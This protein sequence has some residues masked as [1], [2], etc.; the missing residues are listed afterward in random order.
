M[1][2]IG[3]DLPAFLSRITNMLSMLGY[4]SSQL[5]RMAG[6]LGDLIMGFGHRL[7]L[8]SE[9]HDAIRDRRKGLWEISEIVRRN[10]ERTQEFD[11]TKTPLAGLPLHVSLEEGRHDVSHLLLKKY[12]EA[13]EVACQGGR[14]PLHLLFC[15][16]SKKLLP[17]ALVE[18]LI[19][20]NPE[21]LSTA[22]MYGRLPFHHSLLWAYRMG[23]MYRTQKM[24]IVKVVLNAYPEAAAASWLHSC[25]PIDYAVNIEDVELL[26]MICDARPAL[27]RSPDIPILNA[28][29]AGNLYIVKLLLGQEGSRHALI[30]PNSSGELSIHAV[31]DRQYLKMDHLKIMILIIKY[32]PET[33]MAVEKTGNL[34]I[35]QVSVNKTVGSHGIQVAIAN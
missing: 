25:R 23:P 18:D 22:D 32:A 9:L 28:C 11:R 6:L 35:H 8:C 29:R 7:G 19:A 13:A 10:P 1:L 14:L 21:A 15:Y 12:S 3:L 20:A 33:I 30:T 2:I 4:C 31:T 26:Q 16:D 17:F 24:K 34:P 27:F 5:N